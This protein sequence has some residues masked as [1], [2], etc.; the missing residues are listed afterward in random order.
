MATCT[1]TVTVVKTNPCDN[2]VTP[3]IFTNCPANI[4]LTTTL[5]GCVI[6][7]WT[8]PTA[9]DNCTTP[10]VSITSAPTVGLTSGSCFPIGTTTITY[11]ATD[12]KGNM[13]TCTFTVT[14]VKTDP[15]D[16]DLEPPT[17][18]GCPANIYLTT[19]LACATAS[20]DTPYASDNCSSPSLFL[21][22]SPTPRLG[23]GS[24]F[25]IGTTT[26]TYR[27]VDD[28]GNTS[29]CSFTVKVVKVNACDNITYAGTIG[30]TCVNGKITLTNI[31]SPSGG[32]GVIE[33]LWLKSTVGCPPNAP[34]QV[35]PNSNSPTLTVNHITQK[36]YYLRC[37]RRVGC[38]KDSEFIESNCIV[39]YPNSC[40]YSYN[41][42]ASKTIL[43][44][45]A[46]AEYNR[47]LIQWVN[48]TGYKNDFFAVQKMNAATGLF[49]DLEII[50]AIKQNDELQDFSSYDNSPTEGDNSYRIKLVYDDGKVDYSEIKVVI[51]KGLSGI[52]IFPNPS[53]DYTNLDLTKYKNKPVSIYLYN[54]F[55][56]PVQVLHI[57]KVGE[58]PVRLDVS[59][60]NSGHF[61]I[62][63]T[64][65]GKRDVTQQLIITR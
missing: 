24:C 33:Y 29:T 36:T 41:H 60:Y 26:L 15:C 50:N 9:T 7:S 16:S 5:H 23:S 37:V 14:V 58:E 63:I 22:S 52:R 27:A 61:L 44:M 31:T 35:V 45:E 25:P 56:Q 34:N 62:R 57:E 64:S 4:Y 46:N 8:A 49:E 42:L 32:S 43:T 28:K 19:T 11:K 20:W 12:A 13:A 2:D 10:S 47:S 51:F 59:T 53:N 21:M 55:G 40:A 48:N 3:P 38:T 65:K 39:V 54:A 17:I 30:K 18:S 6:A 1:F